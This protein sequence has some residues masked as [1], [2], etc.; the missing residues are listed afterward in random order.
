[1]CDIDWK[2]VVFASYPV[3]WRQSSKGRHEENNGYTT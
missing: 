1:M 3:P 2:F